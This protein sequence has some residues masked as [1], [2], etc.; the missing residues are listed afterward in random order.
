M[1]ANQKNAEIKKWLFG[2]M[3]HAVI[4]FVAMMI[5][6]FTLQKGWLKGSIVAIVLAYLLTMRF[7]YKKKLDRINQRYKD[8]TGQP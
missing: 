1:D 5:V 3:A 6:M 4:A 7:V 2:F 8:E